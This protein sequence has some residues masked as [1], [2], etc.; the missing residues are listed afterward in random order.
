MRKVML[1]VLIVLLLSGCGYE[2]AANKIAGSGESAGASVLS[3]TGQSKGYRDISQ[4]EIR[5]FIY[6]GERMVQNRKLERLVIL[7]YEQDIEKA[8]E[9][10]DSKVQNPGIADR[11]GSDYQ[12]EIIKKDGSSE[13]YDFGM[14]DSLIIFFDNES[15]YYKVSDPDSVKSFT[16]LMQTSYSEPLSESEAISMV[17]KDFPDFP[18]VPNSPIIKRFTTGGPPGASVNVKFI[19]GVERIEGSAYMVTFTKDWG[20]TVNGKY[21]K[22]YWKYNVTSSGASLMDRADMDYLPTTMK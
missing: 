2:E 17:I 11:L 3:Q 10:F 8:M 1:V 13:Y 14:E 19:T 12:M 7:E 9:V 20:L 16:G 4:L 21:V 18:A 5:K 15:H 22:S 6:N